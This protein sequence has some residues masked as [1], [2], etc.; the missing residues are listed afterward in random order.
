M[1]MELATLNKYLDKYIR[2]TLGLDV[3]VIPD[4]SSWHKNNNIRCKI[5]VYPEKFLK[6]S[7]EF[8]AKYEKN[9]SDPELIQT[10]LE[11]GLQL[12]GR[13]SQY[14]WGGS[15]MR[16]IEGKD[17][18]DISYVISKN[19]GEYLTQ[20]IEKLLQ[21]INEVSEL[22]FNENRSLLPKLPKEYKDLV[23]YLDNVTYDVDI[24]FD[25]SDKV[26]YEGIP[27]I[28]LSIEVSSS[29][30][31]LTA[32]YWNNY[33]TDG[34]HFQEKLKEYNLKDPQILFYFNPAN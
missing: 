33:L 19:L 18:F 2:K 23:S 15:R 30:S 31:D 21:A 8:S 16:D 22:K 9:I 11:Q 27:H 12:L 28:F 4:N 6:R 17:T 24:R 25:N 26:H 34:G 10:K 13:E 7:P 14:L 29:D 32:N 20:Y 5:I 3:Y 1:D